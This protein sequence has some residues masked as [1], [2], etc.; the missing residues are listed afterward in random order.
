MNMD[1]IGLSKDYLSLIELGIVGNAEYHRNTT[2]HLCGKLSCSSGANVELCLDQKASP[3]ERASS[4]QTR[5][6][7]ASVVSSEL[8]NFNEGLLIFCVHVVV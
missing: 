7:E 8:P 1:C 4:K 2:W 5:Q 6:Y 3:L